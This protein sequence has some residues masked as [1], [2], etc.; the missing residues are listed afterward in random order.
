MCSNNVNECLSSVFLV[1]GHLNA[2]LVYKLL[3]GL[4]TQVTSFFTNRETLYTSEVST[5]CIGIP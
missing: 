5:R 3:W 2:S 4:A 1:L